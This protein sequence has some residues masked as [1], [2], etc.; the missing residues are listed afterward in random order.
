MKTFYRI[1]HHDGTGFIEFTKENF[2]SSLLYE[3]S[4]YP[5]VVVKN[6]HGLVMSEKKVKDYEFGF[7]QLYDEYIL[8]D[9]SDEHTYRFPCY[10]S[11]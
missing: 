11:S 2:P 7:Y 9:K 10:H 4:Y 6:E 8:K 5:S 1:Y 3:S